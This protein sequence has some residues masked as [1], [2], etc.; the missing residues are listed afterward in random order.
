M[1]FSSE[2][3]RHGN[4]RLTE[5]HVPGGTAAERVKSEVRSGNKVCRGHSESRMKTIIIRCWRTWPAAVFHPAPLSLLP[6]TLF[7]SP[8]SP[9]SAPTA[10]QRRRLWLAMLDHTR[11]AKELAATP[12]GKTW[13][14]TKR[15]CSRGWSVSM[16]CDAVAPR[17]CSH[18]TSLL[19]ANEQRVFIDSTQRGARTRGCLMHPIV[20]SSRS[21]AGTFKAVASQGGWE[22]FLIVASSVFHLLKGS[23]ADLVLKG[24][25]KYTLRHAFMSPPPSCLQKC[26]FVK[27]WREKKSLM[28]LAMLEKIEKNLFLFFFKKNSSS[29]IR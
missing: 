19:K 10:Y 29:V 20:F 12:P 8:S 13:H 14:K 24:V 5:Q 3:E 2:I 17:R 15:L 4:S 18:P 23:S 27:R 16:T 7:P 25:K 9:S 21:P 28:V 6:R 11:F 1:S 22:I 26:N